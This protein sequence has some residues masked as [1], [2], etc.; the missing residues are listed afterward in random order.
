MSSP[1]EVALFGFGSA[2]GARVAASQVVDD[3]AAVYVVTNDSTGTADTVSI[4]R[5][6]GSSWYEVSVGSAGAT[7]TAF[8]YDDESDVDDNLE[9]GVL[10]FPGEVNEPGDVDV[11]LDGRIMSITHDGH[12][13][14]LF[15]G[16]DGNAMDRIKIR[17]ATTA[18]E[19]R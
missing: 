6:E 4:L 5:R 17:E 9:A 14:A 12:W 1:E 8:A 18:R 7:W 19:Q 15:V 16:V 10:A 2:S 11:E 13:I 3:F